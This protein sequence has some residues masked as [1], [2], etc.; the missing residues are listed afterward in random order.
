MFP[1]R[2]ARPALRSGIAAFRAPLQQRS[3]AQ[4]VSEKLKLSLVLPNE[5]IYKSTDVYVPEPVTRTF[6]PANRFHDVE[7]VQV[8]IA[9]ESGDMGILSSH[10]P[11]IEQL[12]P[13]IIEIIEESGSSK[14][15]FLAGGFAVVQPDSTLNIN[16]VEG[17]PLENFS[18]E[19]VRSQIAEAQKAATGNGS[20]KDIA[21]AK[22]ELEVLE[23][24]QNALK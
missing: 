19:A 18:A 14:K 10:V 22:I 7:T 8:N 12:R 6:R 16:A 24:L 5:T 21:E 9:A 15:F 4:A 23:S 17:F 20:E 3:Y 11:S 1:L 2:F 13:G